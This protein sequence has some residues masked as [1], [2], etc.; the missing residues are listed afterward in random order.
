MRWQD[1]P[2][3]HIVEY[4]A[5]DRVWILYKKE[6]NPPES[7]SHEIERFRDGE[8]I[9]CNT[10]LYSGRLNGDCIDHGPISEETKELWGIA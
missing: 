7:R 2:C 6:H 8:W 4:Y 10:P 3:G 9:R 1:I 5:R